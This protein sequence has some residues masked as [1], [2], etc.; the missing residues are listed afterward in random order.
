MAI[1]PASRRPFLLAVLSLVLGLGLVAAPVHVAD[2][3][4]ASY[5]RPTGLRAT[6]SAHAVALRWTAVKKAPA[7]RVQFSTRSDMKTFTTMDV[8][9]TYLEWTNL[10]P[11]PS[12]HSARLKASTTYYFRVKVISLDK[13]TLTHYSK[14]L[15]VKTASA[16]AMPELAP[17]GLTS[18]SQGTTSM[19]LSW[20]SRGPG[21]SYRIR[22]GTTQ[23][24]E[25]AKSKAVTSSASGTVLTGLKPAT[26]YYYKVR[27][28][29][30]GGGDL[31]GYS[32]TASLTTPSTSASPPIKVATYNVCSVA[33]DAGGHPWE[34]AREAAVV[35]NLAAQSPDVIGL[36]EMDR[37]KLAVFLA[38]LNRA[39]G[40]SYQTSDLPTKG[41]SGTTKL[42][43]D[44]GLFTMASSEHGVLALSAGDSGTQKYAV[45]AI[46][47]DKR[48]GKRLFVV[49]NHLVAGTA[50]QELRKTQS[51]EI[52]GLVAAKNTKKLP[53]V[54][55]GDFNSNRDASPS[56]V[57]YD[58]L[59]AAGFKE[60]LGNTNKSWTVSRQ[61]TA[62]H[63]VDLDYSTYNGFASYARRA[64]YANGSD[65]DYIWH[66]AQIR[67]AMTRV[68]VNVNTAGKFVGT[69]PSDHNLL[70]AT[71][72][73]P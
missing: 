41:G 66:S 50:Y 2:A 59:S 31:S 27:T 10:D 62:E 36:Q 5:A 8:V 26:T 61:A 28:I 40:R 49:A 15:K 4:A 68:V 34:G 37:S 33:C 52:V 60:P 20:S 24:L 70:T 29:A 35:A 43:Y 53:V 47:T 19:Y 1:P 63:R 6:V 18:T 51:A 7:Y 54:I 72:H 64:K 23:K 30:T 9:G 12:S 11:T 3:Q 44:T 14:T 17:V 39:S 65:I 67:V 57:V 69:I 73:L 55:A 38:D 58:V 42:A 71:I 48:S 16:K 45:W 21:V 22:Y 32:K 46:L 13:V 25:V 56:N